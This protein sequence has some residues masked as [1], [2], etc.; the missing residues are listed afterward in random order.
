MPRHRF[1][2]CL[3][4]LAQ[5]V[6]LLT[7]TPADGLYVVVQRSKASMYTPQL[8]SSFRSHADKQ[9]STFVSRRL[10]FFLFFFFGQISSLACIYLACECMHTRCRRG[11]FWQKIRLSWRITKFNSKC[12]L[13]AVSESFAIEVQLALS[14]FNDLWLL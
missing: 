10:V 14:H 1:G 13:S 8:F 6:G 3:N 12:I 2:S 9:V 4:W 11:S 5:I 7:Y